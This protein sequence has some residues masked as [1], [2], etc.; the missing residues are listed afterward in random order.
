VEPRAME[1]H[2]SST[3]KA[4]SQV[5][6]GPLNKAMVDP[7]NKVMVDLNLDMVDPSR[8]NEGWIVKVE[9]TLGKSFSISTARMKRGNKRRD[10][11]HMVESSIKELHQIQCT[12]L[13]INSLH[14]YSGLLVN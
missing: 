1:H 2:P 6:V 3:N 14:I 8:R 12:L 13:C 4:G 11:H 9:S 5:M 10:S 7:L